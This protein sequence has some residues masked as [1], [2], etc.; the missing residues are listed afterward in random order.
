MVLYRYYTFY[1]QKL[2]EIG[3]RYLYVHVDLTDKHRVYF[4]ITVTLFLLIFKYSMSD[5]E[6]VVRL[7]FGFIFVLSARTTLHLLFYSFSINL[8]EF[9]I[10]HVTLF[11]TSTISQV[12]LLL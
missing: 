11:K 10:S 3:P 5:V 9:S 6:L 4:S 7:K 12:Y 1:R 8:M 2:L